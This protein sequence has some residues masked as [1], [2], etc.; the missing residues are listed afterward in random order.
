MDN[1]TAI[2]TGLLLNSALYLVAIVAIGLVQGST[3]APR[4]AVA[5][6]GV[7]ALSYMAQEIEAQL[8]ETYSTALTRRDVALISSVVL[9]VGSILLGAVAGLALIF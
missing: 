5:S 2:R 6:L 1:R 8:P 4:L 3:A 9:T 7:A